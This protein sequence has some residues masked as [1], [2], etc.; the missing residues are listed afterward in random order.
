VTERWHDKDLFADAYWHYQLAQ[1][2]AKRAEELLRSDVVKGFEVLV[3]IVQI[4]DRDQDLDVAASAVR[5]FWYEHRDAALVKL[6]PL[7][8]ASARWYGILASVAKIWAAKDPPLA[9]AMERLR[10]KWHGPPPSR[11][12]VSADVEA[13]GERFE[14]LLGSPTETERVAGAWCMSDVTFWTSGLLEELDPAT[15]WEYMVAVARSRLSDNDLRTFG[16]G[17]PEN[18]LADH[19]ELLIDRIESDARSDAR[20]RLMLSGAWQTTEMDDALWARVEGALGEYREGKRENGGQSPLL[21]HMREIR[22]W[23]GVRHPGGRER[24]ESL[25]GVIKNTYTIEEVVKIV[26]RTS[27]QVN[28]EVESGAL[29][30]VGPPFARSVPLISL[31]ACYFP[32]LLASGDAP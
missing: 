26:G 4:L 8:A 22:I 7:A 18:L 31:V 30:L 23:P 25:L 1:D 2:E 32:E 10:A 27:D 9:A 14:A 19:G 21:Q 6:E 24:L 17:S 29:L 3:A 28:E 11:D 16:A 5:G 20:V 15:A 13:S 12:Q